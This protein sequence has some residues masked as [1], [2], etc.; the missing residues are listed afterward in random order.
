MEDDGLQIDQRERL[1]V[2]SRDQEVCSQK[3]SVKPSHDGERKTWL[4]VT[5]DSFRLSSKGLIFKAM[6]R[7]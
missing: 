7:R 5:S 2:V 3:P 4:P 6:R 1:S